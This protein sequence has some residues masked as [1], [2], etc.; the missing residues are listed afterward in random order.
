MPAFSPLPEGRGGSRFVEPPEPVH[1][2]A[3]ASS[4]RHPPSSLRG[5]PMRP[6]LLLLP[7]LAAVPAS[8][9][10][11]PPLIA[12]PDAFKTLVNPACSHCRDEAKRR[13]GDLKD[14][15]RVLSWIRGYS[16]G[17]AIPYRFF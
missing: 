7:L 10:E 12:R 14:D 13:A 4:F 2:V 15:D 6:L 11:T 5:P 9:G 1:K 17:G 16:D 8:A 3:L